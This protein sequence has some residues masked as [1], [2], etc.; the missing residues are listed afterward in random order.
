[1]IGLDTSARVSAN[2]FKLL[3]NSTTP[4][5]V[6]LAKVEKGIDLDKSPWYGFSTVSRSIMN[7]TVDEKGGVVLYLFGQAITLKAGKSDD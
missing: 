2:V 5:P 4:S 7:V 1:M 3:S 6:L